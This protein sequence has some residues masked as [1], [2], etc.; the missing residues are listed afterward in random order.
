MANGVIRFDDGWRLDAG[1]RFDQPPF[2]ALPQPAPV[3]VHS[4]SEPH[5]KTMD[6]IPTK[7]GDFYLW[8]KNLSDHAVAEAAKLGLPPAEGLALKALADG[9]LVKMDATDAASAALDGARGSETVTKTSTV[10][11][12]REVIRRWKTQPPYGASGTEG[13]LQISGS[14]AAFDP[15]SYKTTLKVRLVG[16][17]VQIDFI[18]GGADG[19][20]VYCRLRGTSG[21]RKLAFDSSS[22]YVDTMPLADPSKP[23]VREYMARGVVDDVEIGLDSDVVS[24]TL[25]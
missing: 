2:V 5:T 23:E 18:K 1:H 12:I 9:L 6:Y 10:A 7:R 14:S 21:W 17:Q 11:G 4:K 13:V 8:L 15:S 19:V 16:G 3:P 20:N 24:I 25:I 22:P